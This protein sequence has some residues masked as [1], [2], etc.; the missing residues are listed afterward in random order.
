MDQK[1]FYSW[2]SD[3]P[4]N[5]NRSLILTALE[6]AAEDIINDDSISVVP[7]IDRDTL[8]LS[9]SP[10]IAQSI[11]AKI[12]GASVFVADVTIIDP[13]A[14]K[15]SPNPNVLIEL[16]YAVK[17]LGWNKIIMVMNAEYGGPDT[18][19]FDLRSKRVFPYSASPS[20]TEKAPIRNALRKTLST[21]I[22]AILDGEYSGT[23]QPAQ[24]TSTADALLVD[25]KLFE[26]FKNVLPSAGSIHF[27]DEH[28]MAGF[29]FPRKMLE[30]LDRFYYEWN[31]AE[32]EFLDNDLELLRRELHKT[33]G[34]YLGLIATNTFATDNI[35]RSTVPPEWEEKNPDRFFEV[36][37]KL[38]DT[39]GKIV[40]QHQE[41]VRTARQKLAV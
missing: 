5:T 17:V 30:D 28:N 25:R 6:K 4:N 18:L 23:V 16:G 38:H 24:G 8:G 32:H 34:E 10:D 12:D 39:A 29:S 40:E 36:V 3:S 20:A 15:L 33:I 21:A 37:G 13:K 19:P 41:L 26:Q 35:E 1:V 11:F 31:D 14:V 9:G 22:G 7:V 2:Q 27:I